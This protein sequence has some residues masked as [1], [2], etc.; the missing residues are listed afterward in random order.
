VGLL[1]AAGLHALEHH[2]DRLR[3]DHANARRLA[4]GFAALG[5]ETNVPET[6]IVL[7]KTADSARFAR[8]ARARGVLMGMRDA[9]WLRA[10]THLDVSAGDV[11]DALARLRGLH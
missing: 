2:V 4:T 8:D 9:H 3:D 7:V 6:N 5:F 1:A 11:D 10:V